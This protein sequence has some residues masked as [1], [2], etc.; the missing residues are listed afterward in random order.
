MSNDPKKRARAAV[1]GATGNDGEPPTPAEVR[2]TRAAYATACLLVLQEIL[3]PKVL[4]MY[5]QTPDLVEK[6]SRIHDPRE[7]LA[8]LR[9][10]I[11]AVRGS[12]LKA[13]QGSRQRESRRVVPDVGNGLDLSALKAAVRQIGKLRKNAD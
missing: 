7:Q 5:R 13:K 12:L 9:V 11:R 3:T 4:K 2:E 1:S 10:L 6:I 8:R